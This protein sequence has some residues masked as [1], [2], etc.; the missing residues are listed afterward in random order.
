MGNL[1]SVS[2]R[3][4]EEG[5]AVEVRAKHQDDSDSAAPRAPPPF[6]EDAGTAEAEAEAGAEVSVSLLVVSAL[7]VAFGAS[8]PPVPAAYYI[9]NESDPRSALFVRTKNLT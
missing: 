4:A 3:P 8:L 1:T 9:F 5:R 2:A 7:C 6:W